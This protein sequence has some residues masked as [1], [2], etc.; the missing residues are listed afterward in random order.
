MNGVC[1]C[2]YL[3]TIDWCRAFSKPSTYYP[4][5]PQND[6][7][8]CTGARII[9]ETRRKPA[10]GVIIIIIIFFPLRSY[11]IDKKSPARRHTGLASSIINPRARIDSDEWNRWQN[12]FRFELDKS[13]LFKCPDT[14]PMDLCFWRVLVYI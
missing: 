8:L 3:R 2:P 6:T 10:H 7:L 9:M 5:E 4:S 13:T 11:C 12:W 1:V 14:P